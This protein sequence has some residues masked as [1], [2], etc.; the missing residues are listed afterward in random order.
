M[1]IL[2]WLRYKGVL[3]HNCTDEDYFSTEVGPQGFELEPSCKRER[4]GSLQA[5]SR[6]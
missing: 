6:A 1:G 4:V 3:H 2:N 5:K